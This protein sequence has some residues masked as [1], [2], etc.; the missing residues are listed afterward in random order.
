MQET[1]TFQSHKTLFF[2]TFAFTACFAVWMLNGVLVTYLAA[3]Q[4][5]DWGPVEIGWL[6]GFP[7]LT[8]AMFRL[9]AG[10]LTDKFGGKPI[11]TAL[12]FICAVPMYLLSYADGFWFFAAC[13]FGFGLAGASFSIGIALPLF[14]IQGKNREWPWG[15]LARVMRAQQ[16]PHYLLPPCS[17]I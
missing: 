14:G 12:L 2:N 3:N 1:A 13:S 9:P 8:G 7:V 11:Y 6:M 4:V 16:S 10:I 15:Y 5:Y 17:I